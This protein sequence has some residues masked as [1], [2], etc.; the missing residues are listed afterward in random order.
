MSVQSQ[1]IPPHVQR[2]A[3]ESA[4]LVDRKQKLMYFVHEDNLLFSQLPDVD[5]TLLR[6]QL[7]AMTA[8]SDILQLRLERALLNLPTA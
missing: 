3:S 7:G 4:E 5:K 1:E 6:A 8:Y 2:M